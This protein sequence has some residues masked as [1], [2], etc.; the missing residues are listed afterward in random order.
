MNPVWLA[1]AMARAQYKVMDNDPPCYGDITECNGV[2]AVAE[3][4]ES[5]QRELLSVLEEWADSRASRGKSV[6]MIDGIQYPVPVAA[7][8]SE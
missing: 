4:Q 5:C 2:W 1:A 7:R 8:R 6:P 3:D